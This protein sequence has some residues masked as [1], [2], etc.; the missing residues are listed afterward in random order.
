MIIKLVRVS[1]FLI[2]YGISIDILME[3]IANSKTYFQAVIQAAV[4]KTHPQV[5][6]RITLSLCKILSE[7][8]SI[9]NLANECLLMVEHK[10]E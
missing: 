9:A 3:G 4:F 2:E 5:S 6:M 8:V 7:P 10:R 1:I